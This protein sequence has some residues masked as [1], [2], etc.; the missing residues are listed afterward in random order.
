MHPPTTYSHLD[1]GPPYGVGQDP[2]GIYQKILAGKVWANGWVGGMLIL[3]N[4]G[5]VD[6]RNPLQRLILRVNIPLFIGLYIYIH[7]CQEVQDNFFHQQIS[8]NFQQMD[9][10]SVDT[11][12][13]SNMWNTGVGLDEFCFGFR[14]PSRSYVNFGECIYPLEGTWDIPRLS[15]KGSRNPPAI[16]SLPWTCIT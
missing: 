12:T 1:F 14:P 9:K 7:R 10:W 2:M 8:T 4:S 11:L 6:G 15:C 3:E 16:V 5:D 13:E